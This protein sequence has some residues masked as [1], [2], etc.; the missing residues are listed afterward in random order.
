MR[1]LD[2][3]KIGG[4]IVVVVLVVSVAVTLMYGLGSNDDENYQ[5]KQSIN[6]NVTI[7]DRPG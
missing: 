5:I 1:I 7:I 3:L 2:K 4:I 6:G